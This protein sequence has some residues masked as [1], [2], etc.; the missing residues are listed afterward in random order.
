ML[1][2][3]SS[4]IPEDERCC[5]AH[6]KRRSIHH[7]TASTGADVCTIPY[8]VGGDAPEALR[9]GIQTLRRLYYGKSTKWS[10]NEELLVHAD[11]MGCLLWLFHLSAIREG[12][13]DAIGQDVVDMGLPD[14]YLD[15]VASK[16]E[17]FLAAPLFFVDS[18]L[19]VFMRVLNKRWGLS[20]LQRRS[21]ALWR[22]LWQQRRLVKIWTPEDHQ[23]TQAHLRGTNGTGWTSEILLACLGLYTEIHMTM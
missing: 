3:M 8:E 10:E 19:E 12:R 23:Y 17:E 14:L 7:L 6:L 16:E 18:I 13:Q 5:F 1:Q 21:S 9:S 15:I 11:R 4:S 20:T 2:D 22:R